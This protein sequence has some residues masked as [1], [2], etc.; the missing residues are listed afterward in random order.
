M[1]QISEKIKNI[2]LLF[3]ILTS[4]S[5]GQEADKTSSIN[6]SHL[7]YLY[8]DK[9]I[10]GKQMGIVHI[11]S[12]YPDYKWIDDS[13]EGIACVDDGARAAVFYL[14]YGGLSGNTESIRKAKNLLEFVIYMQ[15][16]SGYLYNFI[17]EDGSI[18][19]EFKTS[20]NEANWWTW[21]GLWAL[22]EGYEHFKNT[23]AVFSKRL[24]KTAEKIAEAVKK[25]IPAAYDMQDMDGFK[26]PKWLPFG[27]ASDQAAV[28][29]MGLSSYYEASHDEAILNYC[30]KL[31]EGIML[32]QEGDADNFPY[33]AFLSWENTWHGWGN[34]QAY[35][36]LRLYKITKN[37]SYKSAALKEI[38]NFYD[39]LIKEKYLTEFSI[40][41][42]DGKIIS[43]NEKKY[44]QIAYI[45]R[46]MIYSSIEAY[47]ITA[48]TV[49]ANKAA[50]LALWFFG[51][52]PAGA[53]MYS[54]ESGRCFDGIHDE[55]IINKNSGAESTIEA[56]LSLLKV[57]SHPVVNNQF[58]KILKDD[59]K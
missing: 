27:T 38:D 24:L 14:K 12:D 56:L 7:D 25:N 17:W 13:D 40:K 2:A 26:R 43:P 28:M 45:M 58:K 36:L 8:E 52:N 21:R 18:N 59:G 19:K 41:K 30:N 29:I 23:D 33:G 49:Y 53:Q 37:E 3:M 35:A 39:Y 47:T 34:S 6:T 50:G 20:V 9:E 48:D 57:E 11:Y 55:K 5:C 54:P 1:L 46:P 51:N 32:M 15:S 42:E 10:A 16:E 44:S 31:A 4:V 22:M